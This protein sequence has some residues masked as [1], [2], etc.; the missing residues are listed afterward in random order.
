VQQPELEAEPAK[1]SARV[2]RRRAK[3]EDGVLSEP[4]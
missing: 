4:A 3:N 1:A 2:A